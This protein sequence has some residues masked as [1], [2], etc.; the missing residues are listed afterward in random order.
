MALA[1][2]NC[3][4]RDPLKGYDDPTRPLVACSQDRA[5]KYVLGPAFLEGT[6]IDNAIAQQN[7]QGAGWVISLT[8]KSQ[9]A[10]TWGQYTSQNIGKSAAFVLDG[11][12]VSAPTIQGAITGHTE[13]SGCSTR[14]PPQRSPA[15]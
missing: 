12:V 14:S 1:S 7:T 8:F 5:E 10:A 13:I 15:R 2:L 11:Q 4:V 3:N 9:G 6:Q